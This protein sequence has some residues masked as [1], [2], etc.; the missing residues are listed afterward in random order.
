M[1]QAL[2]TYDKSFAEGMLARTFFYLDN[3]PVLQSLKPVENEDVIRGKVIDEI[4]KNLNIPSALDNKQAILDY[5]DDELEESTRLDKKTEKEILTRLSTRG[6]LPT[7]LYTVK[8][9]DNIAVKEFMD[10]C[11]NDEKR[12]AET[13]KNPDMAYNLGVNY[14]ASIFAKFY[15][16]KF[17]YNSFI[18]LVVGKREGLTFTVE[19]VYWLY[20]DILSGNSFADALELLQYFVE[21]FGVEVDFCGKTSKLFIDVVAKSKREFQIR[22]DDKKLKMSKKGEVRFSALHLLGPTPDGE[23]NF[24]I[25]FAIDIEEYKDY[26]AKHSRRRHSRISA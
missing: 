13:I 1:I 4:C 14:S 6:E 19:Q 20:N 25:F 18:L 26:I 7:D 3:D 2:K 10:L 16:E 12:I 17:E 23:S 8:I 21:K 15:K 5:L 11:E 22:F 9:Q 24:S